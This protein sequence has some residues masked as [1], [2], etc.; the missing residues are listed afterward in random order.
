MTIPEMTEAAPAPKVRSGKVLAGMIISQIIFILLIA[1]AAIIGIFFNLLGGWDLNYITVIFLSPVLLIIP[2]IAA[3]VAYGKK[4]MK[5]A[6]TLTIIMTV[7]LCLDI[8]AVAG[9]F[10]Y[11][12]LISSGP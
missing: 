7:F 8:L 5:G 11:T 6:V 12:M 2:M 3:W 1:A 9:F 4:N 10:G